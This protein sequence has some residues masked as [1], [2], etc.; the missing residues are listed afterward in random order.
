MPVPATGPVG[1]MLT[2][3]ATPFDA[4]GALDVA[5]VQRLA[6]QLTDFAQ[7]GRADFL[8]HLLRPAP[9]GGA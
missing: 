7:S 3:M 9:F 2:A 1:V 4:D 5:G 6:V 8:A